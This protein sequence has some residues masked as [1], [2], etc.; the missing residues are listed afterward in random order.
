MVAQDQVNEQAKRG[1]SRS[2]AELQPV[3]IRHRVATRL[4]AI[5]AV[6]VI[7]S[8]TVIGAWLTQ[9]SQQA[10]EQS[11]VASKLHVAERTAADVRQVVDSMVRILSLTTQMPG[12]L[13]MDPWQHSLILQ[14]IIASDQFNLFRALYTISSEGG[15]IANTTGISSGLWTE[16]TWFQQARQGIL[17]ISAPFVRDEEVLVTIALPIRPYGDTIGILGAEVSLESLQEIVEQT[18]V[19]EQGVVF[20]VTDKGRWVAHPALT[21]RAEGEKAPD[22]IETRMG[23]RCWGRI[24]L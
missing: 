11:I 24:R 5:L 2:P 9:T 21:E 14:N 12:I 6:L 22:I 23:S 7:V 8:T 18:R 10:M 4:I 1:N 15:E 16:K 19:G 3:P 20:V 17:Y 13:Q